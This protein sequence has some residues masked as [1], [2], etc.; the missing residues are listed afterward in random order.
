[1]LSRDR[2]GG[3]WRGRFSFWQSI[4]TITLVEAFYFRDEVSCPKSQGKLV[5]E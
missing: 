1:M 4:R 3:G 5:A 2:W